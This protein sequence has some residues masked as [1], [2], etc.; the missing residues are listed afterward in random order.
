MPPWSA[1]AMP[2]AE[3]M[4]EMASKA[5]VAVDRRVFLQAV[6]ELRHGL[7]G[8]TRGPGVACPGRRVFFLRVGDQIECLWLAEPDRWGPPIALLVIKDKFPVPPLHGL[9]P[10][11]DEY[12]KAFSVGFIGL[13]KQEIGLIGRSRGTDAPAM[14]ARVVKVSTSCTISL[15]TRPAAIL[16][17][18]RTMKGTLSEPSI[19]VK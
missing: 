7:Y 11:G 14:V 3:A 8:R 17:G 2:G 18:Q 16:P 13:A 12:R 1:I 4:A 9:Q 19:C 15:L 5:A 6:L 10:V